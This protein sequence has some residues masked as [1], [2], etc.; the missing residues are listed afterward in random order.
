MTALWGDEI[1]ETRDETWYTLSCHLDSFCRICISGG[2]A[3]VWSEDSEFLNRSNVV[4]W[5]L[6]DDGEPSCVVSKIC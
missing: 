6:G 5:S 4:C 2:E 1:R 3:D